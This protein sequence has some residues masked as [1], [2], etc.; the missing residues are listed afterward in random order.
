MTYSIA[1]TPLILRMALS[2]SHGERPRPH[3]W[4][5]L[6]G[7]GAFL[8]PQVGADGYPSAFVTSPNSAGELGRAWV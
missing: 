3:G 8:V 6:D 7:E 1:D 5:R 2:M 4:M